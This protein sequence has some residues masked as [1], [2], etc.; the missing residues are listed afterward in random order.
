MPEPRIKILLF[1]DLRAFFVFGAQIYLTTANNKVQWI[2]SFVHLTSF[3]LLNGLRGLILEHLR[4][5]L[6]LST[7]RLSV[8]NETC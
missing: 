2:A 3:Y 1:N 5:I 7:G 8:S 4:Q 6:A